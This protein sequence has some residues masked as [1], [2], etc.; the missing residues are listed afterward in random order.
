MAI[1]QVSILS[2]YHAG[3]ERSFDMADNFYKYY[4]KSSGATADTASATVGRSDLIK[5]APYFQINTERTLSL[6]QKLKQSVSK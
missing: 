4:P 6:L 5:E 2:P 3:I 1:D